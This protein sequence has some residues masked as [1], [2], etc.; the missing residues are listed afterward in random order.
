MLHHPELTEQR[1][2]A[3]L[4][5]PRRLWYEGS[6]PLTAEF[7]HD[8][9]PIPFAELKGR[10][11]R[12][13]E[14]GERWGGVWESAWFRFTGRV[15]EEWEGSEVVF[16]IDTQSEAC[17]FDAAGEPR[18]GLTA[19]DEFSRK[20]M[21]PLELAAR[22]GRRVTLLV[23]AAANQRHMTNCH[24]R[25]A[26]LVKLRRDRWD[27]YHDM[28]FLRQLMRALP[29]DH[30]RRARV[31]YALNEAL[32]RYGAGTP[33]EVAAAGEVVRAVLESPANASAD[34]V[35]AIGHAHMD[36]AWLW[37]LRETVRKIRS[38]FASAL[39]L[40]EEYPEYH[41]GASQAQLY[42]FIKEGYPGLYQRIKEAVRGG[43]WE[44]QGCMWVEADC[45]VTSGESLVRQI[46]HGKRFFQQEFGL[47]VD[48][49]WLPDVFGYSAALPQILR[50][51]GCPYFLTQ[52]ISWNQF[53]RFPYHTFLWEGIDGS[54]VFTHFPPA[55]TYNSDCTPGQ[56]IYS[57]RSF[58]EKDRTDRW[59][60]LFGF[61]DGGGGPSR[62]Q[63]EL[64]K[65]ARNCEELPRVTQE[66]A[67]TFFA[68][69]Q[70]AI[71]DLLVW[72]G[73]LYLELHRG[74][75]TTQAYSKLMN[76]RCELGLRDVEFLSALDLPSYPAADLDRLWKLV[77]LNQFHDII[78]GSSINWVYRDSRRQYEQIAAESGDLFD[79][80]AQRLAERADTRGEGRPVLALNSLSWD[81]EE[82]IA[83]PLQEGEDSVGVYDANGNALPHQIVQDGDGLQA[84]A[85]GAVPS[86]GRTVLLVRMG[87]SAEEP[88]PAPSSTVEVGE[89]RPFGEL[90]VAGRATPS[91]VEG[92]L[93][94]DLLLAEFDQGG[95]LCRLYDKEAR[96]EVLAEGQVGNVLALYEDRPVTWDAWDVDIFYEEKPPLEA[97]LTGA[98]VGERGPLR[99]S[100][101]YH[102]KLP[103]STIRQEVRLAAGSRRLEFV[104]EVDWHEADRML[105]T[106]FPVDV[107]CEQARFEIQYG[108]LSRPTHRNTSWDMARFE[109]VA[110]K[111]ADLSEPGYGVALLNDCKYG[112]KVLGN[113]LDLNLLRSPK[114]PDDQAD[115]GLHHFTYALL[116]HLGDLYQSNVIREGYQ[117][118]VP[119][120]VVPTTQHAGSE[121]ASLSWFR[122]SQPNVVIE[123]V[124]RAEDE[125][126]VI[127]RLYECWGRPTKA[128][129]ETAMPSAKAHLCDLL[130]RVMEELP[131]QSTQVKLTFGRFEIQTVKLVPG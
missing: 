48:N 124:K 5:H 86:M 98:S 40:M 32:N 14:L 21:V 59:I 106:S 1:I 7:T 102:Y 39:R 115:M 43:R 70:A 100:L 35:S 96:R 103:N 54:R 11:W 99:A 112:H 29:E 63:L 41:F 97:E 33:E 49:L 57:S 74:T 79:Q 72:S 4:R 30:P 50:K 87:P 95:N 28:G 23:E 66:P 17:V 38:T 61:G 19:G 34:R 126:A 77:L 53:N 58:A 2:D 118:N 76:R 109:V 83:I 122:V 120:R 90:R 91:R 81:R 73:E 107:R 88:A 93:E 36:V 71:D 75:L 111:W 69:A 46:L 8:A 117:F 130:E 131:V 13:I 16:L 44:V 89:R 67:R 42:A 51:S 119:I 24:L 37:P 27:L 125:E 45:N 82:L 101:I 3:F 64:I 129:L 92:R 128:T 94:N 108:H 52:K 9:E 123:A 55:D 47:E 110:H 60:Y 105:R 31:R 10:P 12:P 84:L 78:P 18:L 56:L 26:R 6:A 25:E 15:P 121:P 85:L 127:V 114:E 68:Q 104:T 22:A 116:P 113:V 20:A 65:R 62:H 80:A